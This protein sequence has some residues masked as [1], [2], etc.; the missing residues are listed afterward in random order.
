MQVIG[1]NFEKI[2]AERKQSKKPVANIEVNS[3]INIK[4]ITQEEIDLAKEKHALKFD[5]EFSIN[6]KPDLA[7]IL[8]NGFILLL[9]EKD[10]SKEIL[11]KWKTKKIDDKIRIPVFNTILTKCNL[12]AL[13][14]EEELSLPTHVPLPKIQQSQNKPYAG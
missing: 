5:F 12:K 3:N 14:L 1:F 4:S 8:F 13:Q 9:V 10:E 2:S 6:Y 11:K 7:D